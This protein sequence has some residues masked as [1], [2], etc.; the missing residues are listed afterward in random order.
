[1]TRADD[2]ARVPAKAFGRMDSC[3]SAPAPLAEAAEVYS[4]LSSALPCAVALCVMLGLG[5]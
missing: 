3:L 2:G 5:P 4:R 1:M